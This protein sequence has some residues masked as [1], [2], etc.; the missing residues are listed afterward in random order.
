MRQTIH[1]HKAGTT[2]Y[3]FY[4]YY[5]I[6][7]DDPNKVGN[8]GL[9]GFDED[10]ERGE[11]FTTKAKALAALRRTIKADPARQWGSA[12]IDKIEWV[13]DTYEW[14]EFG[15][16]PVETILDAI[17]EHTYTWSYWCGEGKVEADGEWDER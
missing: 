9:E 11:E 1:R 4:A 17:E 8:N 15:K 13:E 12:R 16:A 5:L 7:L 3:R 6:P 2:E 10:S 14:D